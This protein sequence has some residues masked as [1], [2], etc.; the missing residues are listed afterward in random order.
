MDGGHVLLGLGL[1]VCA[2]G[3]LD[4]WVALHAKLDDQVRANRAARQEL[5]DFIR[6]G[7]LR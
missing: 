7:Y 3:W 1:L 6:K 5:L 2:A 4:C